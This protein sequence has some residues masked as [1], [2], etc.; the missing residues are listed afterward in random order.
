MKN[1]TRGLRRISSGFS[2]IFRMH[3]RR[4]QYD[5]RVGYGR[6]RCAVKV[7]TEDECV[8]RRAGQ[9]ATADDGTARSIFK[10]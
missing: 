3:S 4:D 10:Q 5:A 1:V 9:Q 2:P 7:R 8:T 6:P